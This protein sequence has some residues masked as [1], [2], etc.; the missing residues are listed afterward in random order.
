MADGGIYTE[1]LVIYRD[2]LF[3]SAAQKVQEDIGAGRV[4][5]GGDYYQFNGDVLVVVGQD[6]MSAV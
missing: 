1:T 2:P 4:V 6:W 3:E 5:N